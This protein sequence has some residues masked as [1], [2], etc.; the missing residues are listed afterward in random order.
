MLEALIYVYNCWLLYAVHY[1]KYFLWYL[2]CKCTRTYTHTL[3]LTHIRPFVRLPQFPYNLCWISMH[4]IVWSRLIIPQMQQ[5]LYCCCC[6]RIAFIHFQAYHHI[7]LNSTQLNATQVKLVSR[8][9]LHIIKYFIWSDLTST[10]LFSN[11]YTHAHKY[12]HKRAHI[13]TRCG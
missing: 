13:R 5:T 2:R 9:Y 6:W 8:V 12:I 11:T 4:F 7:Q 3:K 10:T 1:C